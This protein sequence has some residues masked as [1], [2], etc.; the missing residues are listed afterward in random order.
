[1]TNVVKHFKFTRRGKRR[2]HDRPN[3]EEVVACMPWLEG[4]I[5]AVGPDVGVLMGRPRRR[6][7]SGRR[8][9]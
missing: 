9:G 6:R 5:A 2:I 7:C 3:R 8:S 1:M 4:E